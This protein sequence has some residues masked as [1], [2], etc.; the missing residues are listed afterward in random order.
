MIEVQISKSAQRSDR[1]LRELERPIAMTQVLAEHVRNRV[2]RTGRTAYTRPR[3]KS[4]GGYRTSTA[5]DKRAGVQRGADTNESS[6]TYHR[7]A[8][9]P[10]GRY[11]TTGGMWSGMFVR[12]RGRNAAVIAF[13][14][15]S[16]GRQQ[17]SNKRLDDQIKRVRLRA[18]DRIKR[19][20]G[21]AKQRA[22][23]RRD[24]RIKTLRERARAKPK[25][26]GNRLKAG[27]VWLA[28][29][30]NVVQPTR[31]EDDALQSAYLE[32]ATRNVWSQLGATG[33]RVSL[34]GD[35]DLRR[36]LLRALRSMR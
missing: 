32:A 25:R 12:N 17:A 4:R 31:S 8:R 35:R 3:Y 18:R 33:G 14:G 7:A 15:T 34:V 22:R 19:A 1:T 6:A 9:A 36:E 20:K 30:V 5:Y 28:H 2:R 10:V 27:S 16:L 13:R 29:R 23:Q 24:E 21:A 11:D 26:V